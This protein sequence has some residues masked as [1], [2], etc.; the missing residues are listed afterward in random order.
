MPDAV[1]GAFLQFGAVGA[2]ALLAIYAVVKL[3]ARTSAQA[4]A[5]VAAANARADRLEKQLA[6]LNSSMI[7]KFLPAT[8]QSTQVMG[9]V[10]IELRRDTERG[11]R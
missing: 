6:D 9:E 5:A 11:R 3:F 4:D 8:L 1:T 7:E 2:V 10:L